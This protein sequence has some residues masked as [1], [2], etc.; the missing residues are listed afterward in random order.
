MGSLEA[1]HKKRI[2]QFKRRKEAKTALALHISLAVFPSYCEQYLTNRHNHST[3]TKKGGDQQNEKEAAKIS[4][5]SD[6]ASEYSV[7]F[8]LLT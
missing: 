5:P 6:W 2:A 4:A 7:E 3:Y 1:V 8:S